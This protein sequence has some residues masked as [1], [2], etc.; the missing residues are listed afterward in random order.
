M[1]RLRKTLTVLAWLGLWPATA[2]AQG[3]TVR[4]GNYPNINQRLRM[5][6]T[7]IPKEEKCERS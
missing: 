7:P 5:R 6:E 1:M 4:V 3:V 2:Q